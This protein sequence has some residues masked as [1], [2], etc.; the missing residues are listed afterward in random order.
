MIKTPINLAAVLGVA[1]LLPS[2]VGAQTIVE[3]AKPADPA[4]TASPAETKPETRDPLVL[5]G[6]V[7]QKVQGRATVTARKSLG[8]DSVT[9]ARVNQFYADVNAPLPAQLAVLNQPVTVKLQNATVKE[10]FNDFVRHAGPKGTDAQVQ[11]DEDVPKDARVTLEATNVRL[12]TVLDLICQAGGVNWRAEMKDE[13][14]VVY[15]V[16]KTVQP[17][18]AVTFT[19]ADTMKLPNGTTFQPLSPDKLKELRITPDG[20]AF[21]NG[22]SSA[23]GERRSTF[24]CPHCKGQ[25]T[26]IRKVTA[27]ECPKCGRAFRADWQF[28]PFDGAK[29]PATAASDWKYCPICGKRVEMEKSDAG[30]L[31]LDENKLPVL[32][33]LPIVGPLFRTRTRIDLKPGEGDER[34]G[35]DAHFELAPPGTPQPFQFHYNLDVRPAPNPNSPDAK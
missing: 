27:P 29:R 13:K 19:L 22:Y 3:P 4:K 15:H 32:G 11:I 5:P 10:A 6:G 16:G 20:T 31:D 25:A 17:R 7:L 12:G 21:L 28:C 2:L 8:V 14:S 1:L 34:E 26:V 9:L 23:F 24:T 35:L 30:D 18:G 33:N